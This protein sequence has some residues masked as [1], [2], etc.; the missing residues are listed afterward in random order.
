VNERNER[1]EALLTQYRSMADDYAGARA[2]RSYLDEFKKSLIA[3]L[4]KESERNGCKTTSSQE[5]DALADA[6]YAAHLDALRIAVER[7]ERLR[8]FVK[9]IEM[10]IEVW[11]TE[12]ANERFERKAYAA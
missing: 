9:Q 12:Q 1:I 11:R 7:E 3:M 2:N 8:Y 10:E 6:R 5:R 4:M